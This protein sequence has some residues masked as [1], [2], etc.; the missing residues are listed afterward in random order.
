MKNILHLGAGSLMVKNVQILKSEGYHV[1][2]V[3]KEM[4]APAFKFADGY[5]AID[6]ID[7]VRLLEYAQE[8]NADA[9]LAVNDAGVQA[10][11]ELSEKLGLNYCSLDSAK[12]ST[13]K[14]L[15]R[16][17]W[18]KD[19]IAQPKFKICLSKQDILQ[20]IKKIGYPCV[21]K[22]CYYWGSRGVSVLHSENDL[23]FSLDFAFTNNR[24]NRYII[25]EFIDGLEVTIEGLVRNGEV[26]ILARSDKEHQEHRN[27]KVAMALNYPANISDE[28]QSKLDAEITKAIKSL[29]INNS[30]FHAE[31]ILYNNDFYLVEIAARPGGGHIFNT[32]V[33]AVSGISMP[34]VLAKILLEEEVDITPKNSDG[35]C[36]KFFCPPKGIFRSLKYLNHVSKDER[37]LTIGFELATGTLVGDIYGDADRPGYLVSKGTDRESAIDSA[38]EA[39]EQLIFEME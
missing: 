17:A 21:L 36:Y 5:K 39:I 14:G 37:I 9:I 12:K 3:D 34:V 7:S 29:D 2:L 18:E 20:A 33:E 4:D 22:P 23:N 6:I 11:A 13:D 1:Y 35:A 15:M 27:Y 8:I 31:C 26:S 24:N 10:A 19:D 32:V 16:E 28:L 25:E 38:N 30:A